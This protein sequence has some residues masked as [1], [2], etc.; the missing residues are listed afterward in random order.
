MHLCCRAQV[1]KEGDDVRL[2]IF[3][4][5]TARFSKLL[6]MDLMKSNYCNKSIKCVDPN[7]LIGR[8]N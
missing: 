6:R 8:I 1:I 3:N 7:V 2:G 5:D 4:D